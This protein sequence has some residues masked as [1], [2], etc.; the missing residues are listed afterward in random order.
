MKLSR[1]SIVTFWGSASPFSNWFLGQFTV[2][3]QVFNCGE[4]YMMYAKAMFF[5]DPVTAAKILAEK[6][7]R[8]QKAL[9]REVK[10]FDQKVWDEVNKALVFNGLLEK[11]TQVP[12]AKKVL[13][14]SER[15]TIIEASPPDKI[16]GVG[17]AAH[18]PRILDTDTWPGEN[19]LGFVLM[20]VRET[21]EATGVI[22]L[23]A[24]Q[25]ALL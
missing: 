13:I 21:L 9:G 6:E 1:Q 8:K 12:A 15:K 25:G 14:A 5:K 2:K 18:D 7:P 16:W 24:E 4:Q 20:W 17:L 3:E 23:P 11:F 19:R 10:N 22:T